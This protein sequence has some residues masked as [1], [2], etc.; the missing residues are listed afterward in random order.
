LTAPAATVPSKC[1]IPVFSDRL[2]GLDVFLFVYVFS[3]LNR[4]FLADRHLFCLSD[5]YFF[6]SAGTFYLPAPA[7]PLHHLFSNL[8]MIAANSHMM[9]NS[10]PVIS[11]SIPKKIPVTICSPPS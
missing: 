11:I 5:N 1:G 8:L 9:Q 3:A 10:I 2:R 4:S 7:F 6:A